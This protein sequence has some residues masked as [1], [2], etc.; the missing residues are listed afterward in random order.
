MSDIEDLVTKISSLNIRQQNIIREIVD[1]IA[2]QN[3]TQS[4]NSTRG[5]EVAPNRGVRT[6]PRVPNYKF[7]SKG[8]IPLAV[9]DRV[10][11]QT[12][13]RTGRKGDIAEVEQFNKLYVAV[14]LLENGAPTQRAAKYLR[15][16]E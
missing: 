7:I 3:D 5:S 10:E 16:I 12:T 2:D 15:F 9:G 13:R 8:G 6:L 4:N 11:I 14:R 1:E